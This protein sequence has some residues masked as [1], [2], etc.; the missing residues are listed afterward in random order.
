MNFLSS[1]N[2]DSHDSV[3]QLE[4]YGISSWVSLELYFYLNECSWMTIVVFC[5]TDFCDVELTISYLHYPTAVFLFFP[6]FV[7]IQLLT[8]RCIFN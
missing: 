4:I 7:Y 2:L 3:F 5:R 1:V 8:Q 6:Q